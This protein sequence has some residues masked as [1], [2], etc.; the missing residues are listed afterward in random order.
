MKILFSCKSHYTNKDLLEHRFGRLY[1]L[2]VE[3][4][5]L[6]AEI[7]VLA[8]DYRN[9][10]IRERNAEGVTFE[11]LPATPGKILGVPSA[12][13]KRA[14]SF[15]PDI[16][17]AS[18][19]SHIGYLGL[20]VSC[21]IGSRFVFDVYDYYPAFRGNRIPGFKA[22]FRKAVTG[23]DLVLCASLPLLERLSGLNPE[24][25]LVENGVDR[26]LFKP[27]DMLHARNS[28]G[29]AQMRW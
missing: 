10:S 13:L 29:I 22:M 1:H 12:V 2:P 27:E 23:A 17:I 25:M 14:K 20:F 15:A 5:R 24:R 7:T 11:T 6:G 16:I 8:L 28:L 4:A 19:D 9:V 26:S 3:I 21:R 18:G